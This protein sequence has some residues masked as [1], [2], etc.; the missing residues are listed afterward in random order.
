MKPVNDPAKHSHEAKGVDRRKKTHAPTEKKKQNDSAHALRERRENRLQAQFERAGQRELLLTPKEVEK[1]FKMFDVK[2]TPDSFFALVVAPRRNGKSEMTT[3]LLMDFYN[4]KEK[5]FDYV[6]LFSQT[7]VGYEDMIPP[8]YR[9]TDLKHLPAICQEQQR[10]KRY[11]MK[12]KRKEDRVKS[13]VLILLDDM[14]GDSTGP[15][16]LKNNDMIRKLGVNGRHLGNDKVEGNGLSVMILTQSLKAVPKVCRQQTDIL[17]MGKVASKVER[18][19]LN[20]EFLCLRSD[21]DGVKEGYRTM[22]SICYSAPYRFITVSNHIQTRAE[23][24]DYVGYYN[25]P[26]PNVKQKHLF[27][28]RSDWM[29]EIDQTSIFDT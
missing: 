26:W 18:E 5:R 23:H 15:N 13:R 4:N 22:D 24:Q 10:I 12:C 17:F 25:A 16:S 27:G 11:N 9:F 19:A 3:S 21:R 1:H 29:E 20:Y 2:D 6:F 8:T 28:D 14:I 7:G